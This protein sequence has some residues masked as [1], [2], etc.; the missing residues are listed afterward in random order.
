[1]S[2]IGYA[3]RQAKEY[4]DNDTY[5]HAI[6]VAINV[7]DNPLIP[8]KL[9]DLSISLAIMHDLLEDT[10]Y[11]EYNTIPHEIE[12]SLKLITKTKNEKYKEYIK[13]IAFYKEENPEVYWVKIADIKDHLEQTKTL[14]EELKN[15]YLEALP[16]LL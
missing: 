8:D 7:A 13:E 4:Y 15:K 16:Y 5:D 14:T 10:S 2:L 11:E 12:R 6:R 9:M 3:L 1:M